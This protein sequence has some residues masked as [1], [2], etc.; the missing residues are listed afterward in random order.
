MSSKMRLFFQSSLDI[1]ICYAR[2]EFAINEI[3]DEV[4][5]V[6]TVRAPLCR[7][8]C[9]KKASNVCEIISF[10]LDFLDP[11]AQLILIADLIRESSSVNAEDLVPFVSD[12]LNCEARS[13]YGSQ[14][15]VR[16][17]SDC[18]IDFV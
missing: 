7:L 4:V 12:V 8:K 13:N 11:L 14:V 9:C 16:F 10:V 3:C 18:P 17:S 2:I 15:R 6:R 1:L 5:F